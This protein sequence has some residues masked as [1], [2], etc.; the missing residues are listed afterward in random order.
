MS[1]FGVVEDFDVKEGDFIEY[2]ERLEHYFN[3]N[4]VT[5]DEKKASILITVVGKDTYSILRS[6]VTP[7]KPA[8]KGYVELKTILTNHLKPKK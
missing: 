5:D 2:I 8:D 6:L 7:E 1:L 4:E 3:A